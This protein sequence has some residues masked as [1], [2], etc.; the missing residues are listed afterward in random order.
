[1]NGG[2][3]GADL[4]AESAEGSGWSGVCG[5]ARRPLITSGG[6]RGCDAFTGCPNNRFSQLYQ[7]KILF[8]FFQI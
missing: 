8:F 6:R 5:A 3:G 2:V 1:M 4:R 7:G